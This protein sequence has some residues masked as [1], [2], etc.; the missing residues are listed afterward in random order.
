MQNLSLWKKEIHPEWYRDVTPMKHLI[1]GSFP[2][3]KSKWHYPFYY[4]NSMNRFWKILSDISGKPLQY[5]RKGLLNTKDARDNAVEERFEMMKCL[6]AGVQNMGKIIRRKGNSS[7][8]TDIKIEKF[9]DIIS[10]IKSHGELK[11]I[12]L[13]GYSAPNSTA[14]T[15]LNYLALENIPHKIGNIHPEEKFFINVYD[16]KIECVI[17]NSTSTA[18][19]IEYG[20]LLGQFRK[21]LV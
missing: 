17:L 2:P 1:L 13:S 15:F 6:N 12:L 20:E 7:L 5:T 18:A 16:R 3:H 8:D 9:Q 14:K 10:I 21:Y 11:R 19:R 4:P